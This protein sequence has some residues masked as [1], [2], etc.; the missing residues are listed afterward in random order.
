MLSELK[1]GGGPLDRH[2]CQIAAARII[3]NDI[4]VIRERSALLG[5]GFFAGV[6]D[7]LSVARL[8]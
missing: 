6:A 1:V 4:R 5:S 7:L 3:D 8:W 2:G